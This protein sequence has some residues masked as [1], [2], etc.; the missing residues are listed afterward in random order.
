[1]KDS[2]ENQL[3][4]LAKSMMYK[5]DVPNFLEP[6]Y[7][8]GTIASA[9]GLD[10]IW[11]EGQA[12]AIKASFNSLDEIL[13]YTPS[14]VAY[15][16]I[17]KHTL[18]MIDFFMEKTRGQLPI[19]LTDTQSPLNIVTHLVSLDKFFDSVLVEPDK[20]LKLFDILADLSID[21]N[22]EQVNRI[23]SALAYPGHGFASS[24]CWRGLGMSD[25]NVLMISPEQYL[26]LAAPSAEK[27][28]QSFGG[29][30]FHSC[31]NWSIWL[32]AVMK[33]KGILMADGAFSAETDPDAILELEHFRQLASTGIV[34]NARIVGDLKTIE[35][36]V[37]RLWVPGMKLVV[38]TYCST[39]EE[40]ERAYDM[41]YSICKS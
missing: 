26:D 23:G 38:V 17:G 28:C 18:D 24:Q 31:G 15:T 2:L 41:I 34:L 6:W 12:P 29:P 40:Q 33:I 30:V 21:F 9:Y 7:G 35:Q 4:A 22:K 27:I 10:Y 3:G 13:D 36:Q 16:N 5:A 32:E 19:S 11:N 20:V 39:P 1:M 25:D 8:I 37:K 14:N